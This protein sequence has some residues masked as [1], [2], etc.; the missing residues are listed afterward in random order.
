ML[1]SVRLQRGVDGENWNLSRARALW[2]V[3]IPMMSLCIC[4]YMR[5]C[6]CRCQ[7]DSMIR[8]L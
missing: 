3:Y 8:L 5:V 4:V 7:T 2:A 1:M 6:M